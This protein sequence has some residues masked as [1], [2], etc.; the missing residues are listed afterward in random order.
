[1]VEVI[2]REAGTGVGGVQPVGRRQHAGV[3][4]EGKGG[5]CVYSVPAGLG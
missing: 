2:S 5:S 1:M 4:V 3:G